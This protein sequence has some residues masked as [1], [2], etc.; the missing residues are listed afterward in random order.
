MFASYNSIRKPSTPIKSAR[1]V[2]A[3][4]MVAHV[5]AQQTNPEGRSNNGNFYFRDSAIYSYGSHFQIARFS[6]DKTVVW[7]TSRSYSVST[8]GHV[9]YVQDAL[10]GLPVVVISVPDLNT[11]DET[12]ISKDQRAVIELALMRSGPK[13]KWE[14]FQRVAGTP[15][16]KWPSNAIELCAAHDAKVAKDNATAKVAKARKAVEEACKFSPSYLVP[17]VI[18]EELPAYPTPYYFAQNALRESERTR[19]TLASARAVISKQANKSAS[20]IARIRKASKLAK[21]FGELRDVWQNVIHAMESSRDESRD[22]AEIV[23]A[24]GALETGARCEYWYE[25][26]VGDNCTTETEIL[27]ARIKRA[28]QL[29][30]T[31][32]QIAPLMQILQGR[33]FYRETDNATAESIRIV[34]SRKYDAKDRVTPES[35]Q[36]GKGHA[37]QYSIAATLV[38]RKGDTLET[39]RGATCPF[40][41]AV[42]AFLKAQDC[43]RAGKTWHRNGE[44]IRV[45]HFNVDSI[46]ENGNMIAGCHTLEWPEM[47]RLAIREIPERVKARFGLPV[48]LAA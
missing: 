4:G 24:L 48:V 11:F 44:Q 12:R 20:D 31:V 14:A 25:P 1:K 45:G 33:L 37:A 9:S 13:T 38:R 41:H 5:W 35:W 22:H 29:G 32:E 6:Q 36:N 7:F 30:F 47:L 2:F 23:H 34:H 42:L 3:N 28:L 17:H 46:D 10:R 39:S 18:N 27:S 21:R 15:K 26:G 16:R 43:R 8:S 40:A 19:A